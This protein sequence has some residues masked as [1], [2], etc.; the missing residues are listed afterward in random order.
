VV[1]RKEEGRALHRCW[2]ITANVRLAGQLSR[3][4]KFEAFLA[5]GA[6]LRLRLDF[7]GKRKCLAR[8]ST[9]LVIDQHWAFEQAPAGSRS[10]ILRASSRPSRRC[11]DSLQT[12]RARTR[13]SRG[14]V[15]VVNGLV[16]YLQCEHRK[17]PGRVS[18]VKPKDWNVCCS[19]AMIRTSTATSLSCRLAPRA[20]RPLRIQNRQPCNPHDRTR[21]NSR[22]LCY[23][24]IDWQTPL[25][26]EGKNSVSTKFCSSLLNTAQA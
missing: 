16:Q 18:C 13:R 9:A 10:G 25:P 7:G 4:K 5:T 3:A 22:G 14:V 19:V 23:H 26:N 11:Y 15:S 8:R 24:Y 17:V 1:L 6:L 21:P 12:P 20:R 2:E